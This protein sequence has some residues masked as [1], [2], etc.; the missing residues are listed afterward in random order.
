M[1]ASAH[2]SAHFHLLCVSLAFSVGFLV[3]LSKNLKQWIWDIVDLSVSW[4][5]LTCY[6]LLL[7]LQSSD[8]VGSET[9][10]AMIC[11]GRRRDRANIAGAWDKGTEW[12]ELIAE[13]SQY[14]I[15]IPCRSFTQQSCF[16]PWMEVWRGIY[17]SKTKCSPQLVQNWA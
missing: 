9:Q 5:L 7:F 11:L 15:A 16:N 10:D 1:G 14:D 3:Q 13:L 12:K 8:K 6:L 4:K 17:T 2:F